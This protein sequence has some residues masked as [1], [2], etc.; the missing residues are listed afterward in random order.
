M[1]LVN[2]RYVKIFWNENV[3]HTK[4]IKKWRVFTGQNGLNQYYRAIYLENINE[5]TKGTQYQYAP[6]KEAIS[7]LG[8]KRIDGLNILKK[9]RYPSFE[10]L[11]KAGL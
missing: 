9:A 1:E 6:I 2:D 11:I 8:N 4:K 7:Y 5:K 10:L 3:K